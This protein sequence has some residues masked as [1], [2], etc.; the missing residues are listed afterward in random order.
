MRYEKGPHLNLLLPPP[1][2]K[3][4]MFPPISVCLSVYRIS[5]KVVQRIWMKFCGQVRCVTRTNRL[6][7]GEDPD[8]DLIIFS[9]IL[10]H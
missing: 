2:M 9:V 1:K 3:E 4:V 6:D 8:P 7:F 10:H 5:Q